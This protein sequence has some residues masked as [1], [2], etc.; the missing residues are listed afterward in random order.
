MPRPG[1]NRRAETLRRLLLVVVTDRKRCRGDLVASCEAAVRGGATAVLLRDKELPRA[2]RRALAKRLR[3]ITA[4]YN[5][6][7]LVHTDA[8]LAREVDADGVHLDS[9][10]GRAE[11][12]AARRVVG[13]ERVVGVSTHAAGEAR[14]AARGG[15]DYEFFGPVFATRSHPGLPGK[16]L[17]AL[18]RA[19][20]AASIPVVPVGGIGPESAVVRAAV[21]AAVLG[22]KDPERAASDL[23]SRLGGGK[24]AGAARGRTDERSL[25]AGFLRSIGRVAGLLLGPGDDA[26]VLRRGGAAVAKDLTI[27]ATHYAPGTAARAA[28][29]KAAGRALSDLAAVGAEPTGLMVGL[30][31]RTGP[32]ALARARGLEAGAAAAARAAGTCILGGDTKETRRGGRETV[33]VTALGRVA[34]PPPL[35]RFGGR[36]GD[37]LF[38]TGALGG[39]IRGRHLRP[40]PRIREGLALRRRRLAT[41]CIDVSDGLATDLHRL[42]RASKV[43]ALLEAWR[44]PIHPDA[45]RGRGRDPLSRALLDGEDYELLFAVSPEKAALV[46]RRGVA[47]TRVHRIGRI[48][49][50]NAGIVVQGEGGI[51]EPLAD[52]GWVHFRERKR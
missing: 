9:T 22:A 23:L 18:R 45:R 39:S 14:A 40:L 20:R 13:K 43:G 17:S 31:V 24:R 38:V 30:V 27:E 36:P 6:A 42:C 7:L 8:A 4:R 34:G 35:G 50:R 28:G 25:V 1:S 3:S 32:G 12:A 26:V 10:A 49:H 15:A 41:A 51:V 2:K 29:F 48:V 37:A 33:S 19:Q 44:V 47:G 52:E 21:V 11:I 16:G 46:E 5:A